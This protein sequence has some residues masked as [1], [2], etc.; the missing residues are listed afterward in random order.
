MFPFSQFKYWEINGRGPSSIFSAEGLLSCVTV[1]VLTPLHSIK[2]GSKEAEWHLEG[3]KFEPQMTRDTA[4]LPA[5]VVFIQDH[6]RCLFQCG[7]RFQCLNI[8]FWF[9]VNIDYIMI[10]WHSDLKGAMCKLWVSRLAGHQ[11]KASAAY[12]MTSTINYLTNCPFKVTTFCNLMCSLIHHW[13][14][15]WRLFTHTPFAG[16]YLSGWMITKVK[17]NQQ[18]EDLTY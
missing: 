14:S 2:H 7:V 4:W 11:P 13:F 15:W 1:N 5:G 12:L 8:H 17:Q 18:I 9:V 16:V 6:Q 3:T 10:E